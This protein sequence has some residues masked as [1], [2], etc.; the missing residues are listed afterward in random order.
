MLRFW[1]AERVMEERYPSRRGVI[2]CAFSLVAD[3]HKRSRGAVV[4][5]PVGSQLTYLAI[6]LV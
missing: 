4:L 1:L 6:H 3:H 2:F 5:A